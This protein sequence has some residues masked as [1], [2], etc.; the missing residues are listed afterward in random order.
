MKYEEFKQKYLSQIPS[1]GLGTPD[2]ESAIKNLT[3]QSSDDK[4]IRKPTNQAILKSFKR[5][6]LKSKSEAEKLA[7]VNPKYNIDLAYRMNCQ[8]CVAAYEL[9]ERGYDVTA[10]AFNEADSIGS[11]ALKIWD[12]NI[13]EAHNDRGF[14]RIKSK[15]TFIKQ[16]EEAFKIWGKE[17]RAIARLQW[18]EGGG[19]FVNVKKAGDRVV[20]IDSQTNRELEIFDTLAKCAETKV[21]L[22][23]M[24][25]DNRKLNDLVIEAVENAK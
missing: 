21:G 14:V 11:S 20:F 13:A 5:Y 10:K 2:K 24:R 7:Q 4:L 1:T 17:A 19:H 6:D 18:I 12:F 25:V 3:T 22:W 8:R 23:L 16:I 9:I 15:E